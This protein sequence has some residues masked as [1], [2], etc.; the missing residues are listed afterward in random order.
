MRFTRLSGKQWALVA[1]LFCACQT[2]L[3]LEP[4][5]L[6]PSLTPNPEVT[7][8]DRSEPIPPSAAEPDAGTTDSVSSGP[9]EQCE[10]FD[11]SRVKLLRSD[12]TLPPLPQPP[13]TPAN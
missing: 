5:E 2:L 9:T 1:P 4:A 10:G 6:D 12:G 8:P 11:N 3:D 7:E 13:T